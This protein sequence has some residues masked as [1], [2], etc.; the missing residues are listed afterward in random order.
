MAS[1]GETKAVTME[2]WIAPME[3]SANL[4]VGTQDFLDSN[5]DLPEW[6]AFLLWTG[7]WMRSNAR[8]D[9]RLHLAV[10]LPA[11]S[12]C[13]A[14][15]AFGACIAAAQEDLGGLNFSEFMALSD[16]TRVSMHESNRRFQGVLGPCDQFNGQ[17]G[18]KI[19]LATSVRNW[20]EGAIWI[21][22]HNLSDHQISTD[23]DKNPSVQRQKGLARVEGFYSTLNPRFKNGWCFS[24][25]REIL[26]VTSKAAWWREINGVSG[27]IDAKG[28][29]RIEPLA[30]LVV[31][32]KDPHGFPGKTLLAS[33]SGVMSNSSGARIVILDGPDS[34]RTS[35]DVNADAV[36]MFLEHSECDEY[37]VHE[38]A[39]MAD[40][41]EDHAVPAGLP[42]VLPAG[43]EA[44]AFGW[45][46]QP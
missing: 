31:A 11:R 2:R 35:E 12:C 20:R 22:E 41:R 27:Q 38:I 39:S 45:T 13:A 40:A 34:I 17:P 21:F 46:K 9:V 29:T 36:L 6:I 8:S 42:E 5:T 37:V 24:A 26:I 10:L 28:S 23:Q 44:S 3:L 16:G 7:W 15:A 32:S 30:D 1:F 19:N 25:N 14:I 18:R 4:R 33:S 43:V